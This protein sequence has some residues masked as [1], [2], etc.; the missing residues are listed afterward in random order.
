MSTLKLF[1][2]QHIR[3]VWDVER[4]V[5][6]FSVID[7]VGVLSGSATPRRYWADLK[8][9]L[10][11]ESDS[12]Q[13]Y[14]KIVQLKL[15]AQDG[16]SRE[17][18]CADTETLLHVIQSIPSPKAESLKQWL[19][20]VGYERIEE[21]EDPELAFDRAMET[22]LKKGYSKEWINQRLTLSALPVS[23]LRHR[24]MHRTHTRTNTTPRQILIDV[25]AL[26]QNDAKTGIRRVTRNL[27]QQLLL[28]PPTG[29]QVCPVMATRQQFYRHIPTHGQTGDIFLGPGLSA[30]LVPHHLPQMWSWKRQGMQMHF[31]IYDLLPV[32]HPERFNPKATQN[33]H[34]W[35]RTLAWLA[36]GTLSISRTVQATLARLI[37]RYGLNE[38]DLPCEI[39]PIGAKPDAISSENQLRPEESPVNLDAFPYILMVGTPEPRKGYDQALA[40]FEALWATG[41][42][43][44]RLI[45]IGK[46]GWK[47]EPLIQRLQTHT[48]LG[49]RLIWLNQVG[50]E[51]LR[52][53][54]QQCQGVLMASKAEG[55][56]LPLIET[57]HANKPV[58]ARDIPVF[59]DIAESNISY[60][61]DHGQV[62]LDLKLRLWLSNINRDEI[63]EYTG[64]PTWQHA[65]TELTQALIAN[66]IDMR[67]RKDLECVI[68]QKK[69][70]LHSSSQRGA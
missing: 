45:I 53:L 2:N 14:E 27:Y 23:W 19:A 18:D 8:R 15:V 59:R 21:T 22:Y 28:A 10:A 44:T 49:K 40:A 70:P 9:K 69:S 6:F 66:T 32:P 57:M 63:I 16:K 37:R 12:D 7:V 48:E 52:T 36:D 5:W 24:L 55:Y 54:Y 26:A 60:F 41:N 38:T 43:T 4:Q 64:A 33:F 13:L 39:I 20:R 17:T 58:L 30:H 29:Y 3:S 61:D 68:L 51:L 35:L 11:Q 47:I 1:E 31:V 65:C 67:A 62:C 46:Q 42:N 56:G 34:K 50:N 25:S